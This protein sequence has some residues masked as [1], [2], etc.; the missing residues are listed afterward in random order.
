MPW[1]G[2]IYTGYRRSMEAI[3]EIQFR[4]EQAATVCYH[5]GDK[6]PL[7]PIDFDGKQFC[8]PGCKTVY[9]LLDSNEMC[10]YYAYD[11]NPGISPP[12]AGLETK[13]KY[14][15]DESVR[16]RLVNYSDGQ[17]ASVTLYVPAM[18]CSSCVWL[19][20]NLV[21]LNPLIHNSRVNYLK[22]EVQVTF[23]ETATSLRQVAELLAS[24]GYEPQINLDSLDK[25]K[26][27]ETNR[28]LYLKIG[29]A[30]FS[31]I[32]I[33]TFQFPEYLAGGKPIEP[34]LSLFFN[35]L[36]AAL[37]LPVL[38]FSSA[39]YFKSAWSAF[40]SRIVNMDVPISLGIITLFTRSIFEIVTRSGAGYMDSFTGLVFLLL[41]GKLFEKKTYDSLSFERNY[42]SYFPVSV[43]RK[44]EQGLHGIALEQLKVGDRIVV[45]NQEL[46]PADAILI[47]GEAHIDY[48]FVTGESEPVNR[49]SGELIYAGGRQVGGSLELDV[50]KEVNQS[51]LTELWNDVAF[52]EEQHSRL[53][54]AANRVSR[55]FT[56]VVLA[57]A[58]GS[59]LYWGLG[60]WNLALNAFTA[61]LIVACPCALALSTPFTLGNTLRV[62][63]WNKIYLK[64]TA[65]I[66]NLAAV[67]HV[68]FD[69]TGTITKA[70]G[71][72][73]HL[74]GPAASTPL[75]KQ[76]I[77]TLASQSMH[78]L[79]QHITSAL[80]GSEKVELA[81]FKEFSGYGLQ[82]L[83]KGIPVMLG[84]AEFTKQEPSGNKV[85]GTSEVYFVI[86]GQLRGQFSIENAYREGLE[87][88]V[89][90]LAADV[91]ISVLTGDN[92]RQ[93][94]RLRSIFGENGELRFKQTPFD[95]LAYI[96]VL[97][98]QGQ[99][100]LMVGDG[101]ND[102][103]A[104]QQSDVGV[105][106]T[107][108]INSFSPASDA[109]MDS[110]QFRLLPRLIHFAGT[111]MRI[112]LISFI[113]SF[114]YNSVGIY[115]AVQGTLSPLIAAI[116]MPISSISVVAFTTGAVWYT[117][118]RLHFNLAAGE[119]I[120]R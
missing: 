120:V 100:V 114:I 52:R 2:Y 63:G 31:F 30:G 85:S 90:E 65:A 21:R 5:C 79:S 74:S 36:G 78:P 20:E 96:K 113:I 115:F 73:V 18:H 49:R 43:V 106:L 17:T 57:I 46:I 95:K 86:D 11:E 40:R 44:E 118:K 92:D 16:R 6:L 98:K 47:R 75:D 60:N 10:A 68:V 105:S 89:N 32:N 23:E 9:Q 7:R 62:F 66:E 55:Y 45:R 116:L 83:Y 1:V 88:V 48:S 72:D 102:A 56:L 103:G 59:M 112:I 24:L 70:S 41:I 108:D 28:N 111:S 91:K 37:A 54:T 82:A 8:C 87:E 15:E 69:K 39:D 71:A 93:A 22:K 38:L 34:Q 33:M 12:E 4:K 58:F 101:L 104:L 3:Q 81:Y 19:L 61:V 94:K 51:Y 25:K 13:Y 67:D 84:S 109:I 80:S 119:S 99:K 26:D 35:Y 27:T 110:E 64:N 117:A 42:K 97:Q 107:E 29:V 50:V 53:I 76:I 77:Y 14:L